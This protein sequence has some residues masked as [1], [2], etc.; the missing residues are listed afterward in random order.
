[1]KIFLTG[2]TGF[3]GTSL[4]ERL[5]GT[6]HEMR[7]LVRK[8][9]NIENV[10]KAGAELIT[11]DLRDKSSLLAG[12]EG[13]DCVMDLASLNSFWVRDPDIFREVNVKGTLNVM[14]AALEAGVSKV[15][16]VSSASVYGRPADRPFTEGSA[17]GEVLYGEYARTK[18]EGDEAAWKLYEKRGLPLVMIYPGGVLGPD[19][20][21][22]AG[23]AIRGLVN[24]RI[25]FL[26]FSDSMITFVHV[27]DVAEAIILAAEKN[28]NTG[29]RYL[30]GNKAI[31]FREFFDMI[32]EVS[33]VPL[34]W[35]RL[36]DSVA[37]IAGAVF[38]MIANVIKRPPF[39][40]MTKS[41][42][43]MNRSGI[44]FD[45][46]KAVRELGITYTPLRVAI[47]DE[48]ATYMKR[49]QHE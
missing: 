21:Q 30:I 44:F 3:I 38:S 4:V 49:R 25:K 11:G 18:R 27:R 45:G 26:A 41:M 9:S 5:A 42:M 32:S 6:E 1:M 48:V 34:P 10:K 15:I 28:D 24:R 36:P 8:T 43:E 20:R 22:S 17:P 29:E 14:E 31:S 2:S 13:C 46:S 33:G 35:I 19:D 47:E 37:V 7:C 16:H 23:R 40:G 39:M 12:M